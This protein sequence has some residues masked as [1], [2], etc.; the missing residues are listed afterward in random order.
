MKKIF[1]TNK[2][3]L[4]FITVLFLFFSV[5][6]FGKLG[7]PLIDVQR[8]FYIPF[9]M[10]NGEILL[11]DIL[12]IYGFF[13]YFINSLILK[14][15][16]NFNLLQG[17][18]HILSYFIAI[19]FYLIVKN[20]VRKKIALIFTI[21]LITV[22]IFSNSTFCF[23]NP[24]SYSTLWAIFGSYLLF[25]FMRKNKIALSFLFLG[26]IFVSKLEFFFPFLILLIY[27]LKTKKL[28]F[29]KKISFFFAFPL[30]N[31]IYFLSLKVQFVDFV[32][33]FYT[34]KIMSKSNAIKALY[35]N[36]GVYFNFEYFLFSLKI[37]FFFILFSFISYFLFKKNFKCVSI[38]V[39]SLYLFFCQLDMNFNLI[40]FVNLIL[41]LILSKKNK[42]SFEIL[43]FNLFSMILCLKGAFK[44][45]NVGYSNFGF[46]PLMFAIYLNLIKIENKKYM[47]KWLN[48]CIILIIIAMSLNNILTFR[49]KQSLKT[50]K[51]ILYLQ[52]KEI[53]SQT[54]NFLEN[55]LKKD[56]T[57][58]VLPEGQIFNYLTGKN[59]NFRNS[60][61]TPLDFDTF[62][63]TYLIENL[64]QKEITYIVFYPRNFS[65]YKK[66]GICYDFGVDFCKYIMD[67]YY[68][69]K[70]FGQNREVIIMKKLD[71]K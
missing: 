42:L 8:E 53:F 59:W 45:G 64:K 65:D 31:L 38:L 27:Y 55:N 43:I 70:N 9:Q 17:L 68:K 7:N 67:N 11:K 46:V 35:E 61:F 4:I 48:S 50:N 71:K 18:A 57:L 15:C 37:T 36:L 69:V 23:V 49:P 34:L 22:S 54:L 32:Q 66:I 19:S 28:S 52:D 33:N 3:N 41:L 39:F 24:Y 63:S 12:L 2:N 25:F 13:G 6:F 1:S 5:L 26:L 51:G 29:K 16:D 56:E 10:N 60:T 30:I 62:N 21:F 20:Y 58:I 44:L 40:F 14:I 47:I